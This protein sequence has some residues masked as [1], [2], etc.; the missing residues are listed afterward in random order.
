ML[1]EVFIKAFLLCILLYIVASEEADYDFR[2]VTMVTAGIV[3]GTVIIDAV[4]T[5]F[6]GM[7]ALLPIL[8]FIVFMV[9]QF[10][11]VRLGKALLIAVP[12]LILNIMIS[13]AAMSFQ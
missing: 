10:C 1:F 2:K 11:W 9:M 5:R 13:S 8:A 6:I 12:F 3:L 7:L 4:L